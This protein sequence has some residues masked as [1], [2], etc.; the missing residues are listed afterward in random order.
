MVPNHQS[1]KVGSHEIQESTQEHHKNWLRCGA[2][3]TYNNTI[4]GGSMWVFRDWYPFSLPPLPFPTFWIS[5]PSP[6]AVEVRLLHRFHP[7]SFR[8]NQNKSNINKSNISRPWSKFSAN[9]HIDF[10]HFSIIW[11]IADIIDIVVLLVPLSDVEKSPWPWLP[12]SFCCKPS[13][14]AEPGHRCAATQHQNASS[15]AQEPLYSIWARCARETVRT[16]KPLGSKA[17]EK[18]ATSGSSDLDFAID[19]THILHV[20]NIYQHLPHKS[21]SFVGKYTS[22][23]VRIWVMKSLNVDSAAYGST[24]IGVQH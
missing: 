14:P 3:T 24:Y 5:R 22:T 19:L 8:A 16:T 12:R 21:P 11:A 13:S 10:T 20:W 17:R 7:A 6:P 23:M 15:W 4:P 9:Y 1:V 2:G 18:N